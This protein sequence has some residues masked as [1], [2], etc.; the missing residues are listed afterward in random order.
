M[1][2]SNLVPYGGATSCTK[3]SYGDPV[4]TRVRINGRKDIF[5]PGVICSIPGNPRVSS[6]RYDVTLFG[7]RNVF[8]S[9]SALIKIGLL[10]YRQI[11]QVMSDKTCLCSD[12]VKDEPAAIVSSLNRIASRKENQPVPIPVP[13]STPVPVSVP[14]PVPPS[15]IARTSSTDESSN[16]NI[17]AGSQLSSTPTVFKS[18]LSYSSFYDD[19]QD[20]S[21]VPADPAIK[22]DNVE[23][24]SDDGE[25]RPIHVT[26]DRGTSPEPLMFNIGTCTDPIMVDTSTS[27]LPAT[28]EVATSTSDCLLVL[29][30]EEMIS[31]EESLKGKQNESMKNE[32]FER[33]GDDISTDKQSNDLTIGMLTTP[34]HSSTPLPIDKTLSSTRNPHIKEQVLAC[35]S[36]DGWYYKGTYVCM[37]VCVCM[38]MCVCMYIIKYT[39]RV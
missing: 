39:L 18:S 20:Q 1:L 38:Y 31:E 2:A 15:T 23:E 28:N 30:E 19:K 17:E 24:E 8:C 34:T 7:G 33:V 9:R 37:C 11:C 29:K 22:D 36:D 4:L 21:E 13:V 26:I 6:A 16:A 10:R 12:G 32:S 5:M 14:V 27:T 3:L 35:W 25:M